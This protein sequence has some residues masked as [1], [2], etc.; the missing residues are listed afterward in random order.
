MVI[1]EGWYT[2]VKYWVEIEGG[3]TQEEGW[4]FKSSCI[5]GIPAC[6]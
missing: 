6:S 1:W 3:E 5:V 4:I 2:F